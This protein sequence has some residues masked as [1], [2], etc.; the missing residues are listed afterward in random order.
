MFSSTKIPMSKVFFPAIQKMIGESACQDLHRR[1]EELYLKHGQIENPTLRH[2]LVNGILPGLA[3]YQLLLE[4][5]KNQLEALERI[6]QIFEGLFLK[7]QVSMK[8]LGRLPFIYPILRLIIKPA[9]RKYPDEGWAKDWNQ[10]DQEAI[11]FTMKSCFYFQTLTRLGAPE[12][13]AS[14]CRVDDFIYSEMSPHIE[15][16]RTLTIARGNEYCDFCFANARRVIK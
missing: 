15:W 10:N 5:G 1:Y 2:H 7:N 16:R 14:F 9:M 13:T 3:L 4:E 11:R 12:L 6:D 8:K